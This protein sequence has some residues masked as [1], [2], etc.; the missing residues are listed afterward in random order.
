MI[1]AEEVIC[2]Y[3]RLSKHGIRL[4]IIG[5]WG[6][7]A[8]LRAQTRSHKDLDVLVLVDDVARTR[9]LL[10]RDGYRLKELWSENRSITDAQGNEVATAFVLL[11]AEGREF[12]A[13]ALRLDDQGHGIPAWE[14]PNGFVYQQDELAARGTIA[15]VT[16]Q[17]ITAEAQ[18]R[19]HADYVL[20]DKHRRDLERLHER[21]GV[22]YPGGEG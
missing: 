22:V 1:S 3:Q 18:M 5:G 2:I 8:L 10:R 9:E 4:W 13:H 15:G 7:D 11:D 19:C 21:F 17:C 14:V 12:D 20:P 16:V 6:I